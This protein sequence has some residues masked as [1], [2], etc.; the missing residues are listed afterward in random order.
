M[1]MIKKYTPEIVTV[2]IFTVAIFTCLLILHF[3]FTASYADEVHTSSTATSSETTYHFTLTYLDESGNTLYIESHQSD[4]GNIRL[5]SEIKEM[6]GYENVGWKDSSGYVYPLGALISVPLK[7]MKAGNMVLERVFVPMIFNIRYDGN[8]ADSGSTS[9]TTANYGEE[10][11]YSINGFSKTGLIFAGWNTKADG[12]GSMVAEGAKDNSLHLLYENPRLKNGIVFILYAQWKKIPEETT[13]PTQA[14]TQIETTSPQEETKESKPGK[15]E[16]EATK[17]KLE[18]TEEET[19]KA[20]SESSEEETT[21]SKS[22]KSEEETA[23]SKADRLKNNFPGDSDDNQSRNNTLRQAE[24][25][26]TQIDD[27]TK[28]SLQTPENETLPRYAYAGNS[29]SSVSSTRRRNIR[30]NNADSIALND[31][32]IGEDTE[33]A[34]EEASSEESSEHIGE[35]NTFGLN[36]MD[37]TKKVSTNNSVSE[38]GFLGAFVKLSKFVIKHPVKAAFSLSLFIL[39]ALSPMVL[40][41]FLI[42]GKGNENSKKPIH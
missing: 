7:Y 40:R 28:E 13:V 21:K 33:T 22:E 3:T 2:L 19:T 31:D 17:S 42:R 11:A 35:V 27:S 6:Y 14:E 10:Y 1:K 8:G 9:S 38:T 12:S 39:L 15:P 26:T 34:T 29:G 32:N 4:E 24:N 25:E 16:E 5:S 30:R 36:N 41:G 20:K 18:K 23:E 37:K